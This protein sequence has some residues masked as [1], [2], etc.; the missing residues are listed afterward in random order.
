MVREGTS[1]ELPRRTCRS[2]RNKRVG[3]E[4]LVFLAWPD[5]GKEYCECFLRVPRS[6]PTKLAT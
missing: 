4:S 2:R 6:F 3:L 5:S 1:S